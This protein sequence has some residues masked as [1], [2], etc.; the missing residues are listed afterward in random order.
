MWNKYKKYILIAVFSIIILIILDI[1]QA[2]IFQNSPVLKIRD[3]LME[4]HLLRN[5][6]IIL[7]HIIN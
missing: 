5:F 3:T 1:S 6:L 7:F 4:G 2:L